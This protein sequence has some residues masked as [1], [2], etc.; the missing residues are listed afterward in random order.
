MPVGCSLERQLEL[1]SGWSSMEQSLWPKPKSS[2]NRKRILQIAIGAW[3]NQAEGSISSRACRLSWTSIRAMGLRTEFHCV[4]IIVQSKF[5]RELEMRYCISEGWWGNVN[6][7]NRSV[8]L[9]SY[10]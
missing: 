6:L 5:G 10:F 9:R 1:H 7:E 8:R 4:H 3:P 2:R